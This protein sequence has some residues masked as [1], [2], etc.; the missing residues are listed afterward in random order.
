MLGKYMRA[1]REARG[2]KV[3]DLAERMKVTT[4]TIYN[5]ENG[6][7]LPQLSMI[8]RWCAALGMTSDEDRHAAADALA[9]AQAAA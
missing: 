9:A 3:G 7:R 5:W 8:Y 1:H 6:N 2:V 4:A